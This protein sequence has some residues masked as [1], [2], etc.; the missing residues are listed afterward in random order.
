MKEQYDGGKKTP[1]Y[2]C[3]NRT[4]GCHAECELYAEAARRMREAKDEVRKQYDIP[5]NRKPRR[6]KHLM[7]RY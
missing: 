1:C 6:D 7:R 2:G 4:V 5:I 3:E